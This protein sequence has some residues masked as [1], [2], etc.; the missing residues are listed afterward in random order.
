MPTE[1][2]CSVSD[3]AELQELPPSAK[4]VAKTLEYEGK[5][6]QSQLSE[7]TLLPVRTVRS[8]LR[9]LEE[10]DIVTARISTMD[11]RQQVYSLKIKQD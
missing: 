6:T 3:A 4:L 10:N 9:M 2:S 11:A 7:S 1:S 8:A 5:L